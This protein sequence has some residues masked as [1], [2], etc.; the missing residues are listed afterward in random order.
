M[1]YSKAPLAD[2]RLLL[3]LA[4]MVEP[5]LPRDLR[6]IM[7][8]PR[9][10]TARSVSGGEYY[11]LGVARGIHFALGEAVGET[12]TVGLQIN[13]DGVPLFY[14]SNLQMWPICGR[15]VDPQIS[16]PFLIG[17][18]VV[19]QNLKMFMITEMIF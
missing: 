6:T 4:H 7:R 5:E 1:Q 19:I 9:E 15:V 14:N 3:N 13:I 12:Q 16:K 2:K 11:H 8:Y 10:W 17:F 18:I